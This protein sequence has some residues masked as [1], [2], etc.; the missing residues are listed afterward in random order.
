[1]NEVKKCPDGGGLKEKRDA[2]LRARLVE[3]H[4]YSFGRFEL[5][6]IEK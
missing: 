3:G 5:E 1:M 2:V 6:E 4:R